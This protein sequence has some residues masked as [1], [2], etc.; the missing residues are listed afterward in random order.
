[1]VAARGYGLG[2]ALWM[3]ALVLVY[4][5]LLAEAPRPRELALAGAALALSVTAYLIFAAPAATLAGM[6]VYL[7]RAKKPPEAARKQ[8]QKARKGSALIWFAGPI[9]AITVLFLLLAPVEDMKPEQFYTG[10]S[11]IPES[12]RSL[13]SVSLE[14]SGPLRMQSWM[15]P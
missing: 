10:V 4:E 11:S 3:W 6:T 2:L 7:L 1:M 9:G 14:H 5:Q 12:L 13:A 15:D 8:K